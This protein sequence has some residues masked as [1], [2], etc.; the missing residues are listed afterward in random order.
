MNPPNGNHRLEERRYLR[1]YSLNL[2]HHCVCFLLESGTKIYFFFGKEHVF[3]F[4]MNSTL[5]HSVSIVI[6]TVMCLFH[7]KHNTTTLQLSS[8]ICANM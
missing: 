3:F 2:Y 6:Y 4:N 7:L 1:V 8:M 5:A